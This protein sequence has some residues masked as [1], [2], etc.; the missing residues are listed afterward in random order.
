MFHIYPRTYGQNEKNTR[1]NATRFG[2]RRYLV[3]CVM[4]VAA[5]ALVL[6]VATGLAPAGAEQQMVVT[7]SRVALSAGECAQLVA[8]VKTTR[9][10]DAASSTERSELNTRTSKTCAIKVTTRRLRNVSGS[11]LADLGLAPS[12]A[13]A[14]TTCNGFWKTLGW[15]AA[16]VQVWTAHV[17]VGMCW[18]YYNSAWKSWGPDCYV[19]TVPAY[20]ADTSWCGVYNNGTS[21]AQPGINFDVYPYALP[22][23]KGYHYMRF[24]VYYNGYSSNPWGS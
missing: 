10:A 6:T 22:W 23:Y 15:Y 1:P 3:R 19:T 2:N 11:T 14:A 16:G 5:S 12:T 8:F 9:L 4:A 24:A 13:S 21:E 20:G 7:H 17:N 18:N